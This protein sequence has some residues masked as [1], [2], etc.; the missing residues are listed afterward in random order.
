M[1][2]STLFIDEGFGSLDNHTL[3]SAMDVLMKL[4]DSGRTVGV[5]THV[6]AMQQQLPVGIRINKTNNGSTLEMNPH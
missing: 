6:E 4:H 2:L 3:D 5:I 1:E